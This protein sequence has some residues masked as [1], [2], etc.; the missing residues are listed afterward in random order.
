MCLRTVRKWVGRYQAE[1]RAGLLDRS[2]R[3]HRSPNKAPADI[4]AR[5]AEL[6]R[7]RWTGAQIAQQTGL[8]KATA[9]R[10]LRRLIQV[11]SGDYLGEDNI[12]R[13]ADDYGRTGG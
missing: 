13:L 5:V 8:S 11:K 2:S 7:R 4:E 3:P 9:H 10:V 1:G 12:V 6:R